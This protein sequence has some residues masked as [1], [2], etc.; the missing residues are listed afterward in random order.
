METWGELMHAYLSSAHLLYSTVRTVIPNPVSRVKTMPHD[1]PT[2]RANLY[3]LSLK[4]SSKVIQHRVQ[5]MCK[6]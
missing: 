4:L 2:S 5:L 6:T 3:N 1:L